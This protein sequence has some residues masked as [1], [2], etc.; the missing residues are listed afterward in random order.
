VNKRKN[1]RGNKRKRKL[2]C[3]I[4]PFCYAISSKKEVCRRHLRNLFSNENIAK[5]TEAQKMP[6]VV[7]SHSSSLI[8]RGRGVDLKLQENKRVNIILACSKI[9]GII[10][11]PGETFSFWKT[12]GKMSRKKGYMD[13]RIIKNGKLTSGLGG[14]ICNLA[15]TINLIVLHSPLEVTE[16]HHHSDAVNFHKG[17]RAALSEGTAIYYN[18]MD[19]KFKNSTSQNVQLLLWCEGEVLY[20]ELR[21]E[22]AFPYRY[23][24][25]EENHHYI[26]EEGKFYRN[27][28]IYRETFDNVTGES[29]KKELILDNH[30]TVLFDYDLIPKKEIRAEIKEH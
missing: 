27:S 6:V 16:F 5:T 26:K 8:R 9:S 25:F 29:L 2:F 3:E 7:S 4:N 10:I 28:E 30:S 18:N 22:K 21:S 11:R 24:L 12:V 13:G 15:N 14:G 20:A 1:K 23:R 17:K 19:Y